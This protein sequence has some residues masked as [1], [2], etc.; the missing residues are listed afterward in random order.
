MRAPISDEV[1]S[2]ANGSSKLFKKM[3]RFPI[4]WYCKDRDDPMVPVPS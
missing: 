4:E 3:P 2:V 1:K